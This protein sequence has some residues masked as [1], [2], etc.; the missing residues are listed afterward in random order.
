MYYSIGKSPEEQKMLGN[1]QNNLAFGSVRL[2]VGGYSKDEESRRFKPIEKKLENKNFIIKTI[3]TGSMGYKC[4]ISAPAYMSKQG[5]DKADQIVYDAL[6]AAELTRHLCTIDD[7]KGPTNND[8]SKCVEK[9]LNIL[10]KLD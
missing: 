8:D 9:A 4:S 5:K 7:N 6:K 1:L 2:M 3:D 10:D